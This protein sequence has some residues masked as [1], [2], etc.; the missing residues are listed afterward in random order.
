MTLEPQPTEHRAQEI[1]CDL[2]I[3][4]AGVAGLNAL[5]AATRYLSRDRKVVLVDRRP[6]P[7]GMWHSVY[8]YVR[9]HQPHPSFTA[10][11]T[12][13]TLGKDPNHLATRSEIIAH[14][15]HCLE[16]LRQR[17]TLD[18]RFG[19]EYRAHDEAGAAADEV[20]VLCDAT[21]PVAPPLRIKAKKLVKAFGYDVQVKQPLPLSSNQVRSVSPDTDDVLGDEMAASRAPVYIAGGGKTA[22]D[23]AHALITRFPDKQV[24]LLIGKGTMFTCRDRLFPPGLKRWWAGSTPLG[25]FLDVARRFDGHN[26]VEALAYFRSKY[27]IALVPDAD[28]FMFGTLGE[29]EN[30]AIAAGAHEIIK[31]YLTDVV[32]RDGRPTLVL[33]SGESR[34]LE[35]GSVIVNCTGYVTRDPGPYEPYASQSGK[36]ISIQ[37]SST[38]HVLS[39]CS[40]YLLVHLS[41]LDQLARLPLYELDLPSLSQAS[42]EASTIGIVAHMIYNMGLIL[43]AV[44]RK[45]LAE[46]GTD[47]GRWFPAPRRLV[48]LIR[49]VQYRK[50][51]PDHMRRSLDALRERF[52]IR[53]GPLQHVPLSATST[54][55]AVSS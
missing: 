42:R 30:A 1:S 8:D 43:D 44:P 32:D 31:D 27:A 20:L 28:R 13:W 55:L 12:P 33:R 2:C 36:V 41:Y 38:I 9:L 53:C 39:T 54:T 11:N 3:L 14:L 5:F 34:P 7:G 23:T 22:M 35:P 29:D 47:V 25:T 50:Q 21:S 26:E 15:Q 18:E 10:G 37:S 48:D 16:V 52:A 17:V 4:G 6:S 24:S 46:F 49:L 40:A 45:V 19:Y 51:N